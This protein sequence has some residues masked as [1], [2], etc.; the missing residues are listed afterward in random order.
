M[1]PVTTD[2]P[3]IPLRTAGWPQHR[4]PRWAIVASVA[5]VGIGVAVGIS[6]RPTTAERGTDLRSFL[7]TLNSD[8][9]SCSGGIR[10]SLYVLRSIDSGTSHDVKTALN[11][12]EAASANCSPAN[13]EL[14]DDLTAEQP[15]ESLSSYHLQAAIT[16]LIN[17]AAPDAVAVPTDIATVLTD[18]GKPAEAKARLVLQQALRKLDAQRAVVYGALAPAIRALSPQSS[19]PT[20]YG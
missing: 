16:D 14:I 8:I 3:H 10:D 11:V 7:A 17:W 20:L 9:E 4:A 19:P 15:P 18:R 12:A 2:P 13:N 6:H 5:L 1:Q